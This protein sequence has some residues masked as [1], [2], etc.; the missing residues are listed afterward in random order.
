MMRSTE[1]SVEGETCRRHAG[2]WWKLFPSK[3]EAQECRIVGWP[4]VGE[5]LALLRVQP[6][7]HCFTTA[8]GRIAASS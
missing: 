1:R 7:R 4:L 5:A 6:S 8:F 2:L 3:K